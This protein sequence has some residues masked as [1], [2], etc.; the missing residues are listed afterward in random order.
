MWCTY[1]VFFNR[2]KL[3]PAYFLREMHEKRNTDRTNLAESITWMK[4]GFWMHVMIGLISVQMISEKGYPALVFRLLISLLLLPLTTVIATA[5][6]SM[7]GYHQSLHRR[8]KQNPH[9]PTIPHFPLRKSYSPI[10]HMGLYPTAG[11]LP[12]AWWT[13]LVAFS[14]D[15]YGITRHGC[16]VDTTSTWFSVLCHYNW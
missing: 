5:I 1:S 10:C 4:V 12:R 6:L 13:S 8:V 11:T 2:K 16:L 3:I 9:E 15:Q 7:A 14:L